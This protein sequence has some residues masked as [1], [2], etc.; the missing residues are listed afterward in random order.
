MKRLLALAALAASPTY[1][2]I[3]L[4][5]GSTDVSV[6]LR[7]LIT[8]SGAPA[9][10][11]AFNA[12]GMHV[13][14]CRDGAACL[15]ISLSAGAAGTE[16]S[17]ALHADGAWTNL[18]DGFYE[19]DVP[20]QAFA[21]RAPLS[22]T[23][24]SVAIKGGAT[25]ITFDSVEIWLDDRP[26]GPRSPCRAYP[27]AGLA[28]AGNC[29]AQLYAV[30]GDQATLTLDA[31][32]A[33]IGAGAMVGQTVA[34]YDE[35]LGY[36]QVRTIKSNSGAAALLNRPFTVA[37][38]GT[39]MR[40][41]SWDTPATAGDLVDLITEDLG[42]GLE[43]QF[44]G[45]NGAIISLSGSIGQVSGDI[46]K[47]QQRPMRRGASQIFQFSMRSAATNLPMPGLTSVTC[48]RY[49]D[50]GPVESCAN[51]VQQKELG[52]YF[53][54]L[55]PSDIDGTAVTLIFEAPGAITDFYHLYTELAAE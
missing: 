44:A 48:R 43:A 13:Q 26:M 9:D 20:D 45:V 28:R 24:W 7:A 34:V 54:V 29:L 41:T 36:T 18:G 11:V 19:L 49:I 27:T 55:A 14:Y 15:P 30:V 46:A 47:L 32:A 42:G 31:G 50:T 1:G 53:V 22:T 21:P 3:T 51:A 10:A 12:A 38:S 25:G 4:P 35:S 2:Q 5:Y 6:R 17:P 52:A 8:A 39:D 23:P 40:T 33:P 37:P 16:N